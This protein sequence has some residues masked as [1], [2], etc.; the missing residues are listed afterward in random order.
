MT[1]QADPIRSRRKMAWAAALLVAAAV[2]RL[3][4]IN[5]QLWL[6]EIW[7]IRWGQSARSVWEVFLLHTDNNHW[8]NTIYLRCLGGGRP[9]WMYHVLAEVTGIG[10]V[11]LGWRISGKSC[12]A[13]V[14]LGAS[15]F[16]VEYSTD[17][18]GDAPAGFFAL[19]CVWMMKEQLERPGEWRAVALGVSACLGVVSH[20][21]FVVILAGLVG[22][23]MVELRRQGVGPAVAVYRT[24]I[25]WGGAG[26]LA[27][28]LYLVD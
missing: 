16:L 23:W 9:W 11:V 13:L 22:A 19:L 12:V 27:G 14:L 10:T 7:S 2:V 20:F 26:G 4:G 6:D 17:A 8:L 18:R 21:T 25:V 28:L 15:D 1:Q 5:Q 24:L 3:A